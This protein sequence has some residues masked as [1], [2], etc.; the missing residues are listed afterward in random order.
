MDLVISVDTSVCHL[1]GSMGIKCNTIIPI[2][3]D[4]RWFHDGDQTPWYENMTIYRQNIYKQWGD[5]I[6]KLTDDL[7]SYW[8]DKKK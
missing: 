8:Q 4:W 5:V 3:N 6:S 7:I 2:G 1:A